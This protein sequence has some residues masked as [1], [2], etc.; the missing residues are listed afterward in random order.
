MVS[1]AHFQVDDLGQVIGTFDSVVPLHG[2]GIAAQL[3]MLAIIESQVPLNGKGFAG[4]TDKHHNYAHV[5]DVAPVTAAVAVH[6]G[7]Q[8]SQDRFPGGAPPGADPPP[9]FHYDSGGHKGR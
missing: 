7:T 8:G 3:G 5:D 1:P 6:H 9:Q 2:E 4:E